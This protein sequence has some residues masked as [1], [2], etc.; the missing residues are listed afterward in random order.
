MVR[1]TRQHTGKRRLQLAGV[2]A[3]VAVLVASIVAAAG[4]LFRSLQAIWHEQYRV[5]DRELDVVITSGKMVHPDIVTLHFGLTNGANLA[6]IPFAE[7]REKLLGRIPNIRDIKIELRRPKRVTVDVIEREPAVRIAPAKGHADTEY[8]ADFEGMVFPFYSNVSA[9][10]VI[11][12]ATQRRTPPGKRLDGMAAAA[13]RLVETA[14]APEFAEISIL[15]VD[16]SHSDYLLAT[17]SNYSRAKIAWDHMLDDTRQARESLHRQY[18]HLMQ[19]MGAR[20]ITQ[21]TLWIAT[22]YGTPVRIY[23]KDPTRSDGR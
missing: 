16:T 5:T 2:V 1:R 23:A 8:V 15:E 19:V 22:D 6:T 11:R 21:P 17:M 10:P 20:I 18:L 7:K 4:I 13:L 3:V 14:A 9:L 12:E